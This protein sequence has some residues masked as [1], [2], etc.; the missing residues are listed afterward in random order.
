Q[1]ALIEPHLLF[2][3]Q[4]APPDC[5]EKRGAGVPLVAMEPDRP[6]GVVVRELTIEILAVPAR[7]LRMQAPE[8]HAVGKLE[9]LA[10]ERELGEELD[11]GR[12]AVPDERRA[13]A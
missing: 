9:E 3:S 4:R 13:A 7:R 2:P 5:G 11:V 12:Q 8:E 10:V 6:Q 1:D